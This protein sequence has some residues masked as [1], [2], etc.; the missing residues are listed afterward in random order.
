MNFYKEIVRRNA[1]MAKMG[2]FFLILAAVLGLYATVNATQVL[3]INSMIKPIKFALSTWIYAWSMAYLL[4][5]VEKQQKVRQYTYLAVATMLYENGV[6]TI[7]AFRGK[8]SHFNQS[9]IVGGI[10]YALMGIM[11]VWL[12]TATLVLTIR[13]IRQKTYIISDSFALSIQIGLVMFVIFSFFGGYMSGINSHNVGGEIGGEGLY[14][15]NWSTLFGDLRVAHFFG[16]HSLQLIPIFGYFI[17]QNTEN[18][19][20]E[21]QQ[22]WVF[23]ALYFLFVVFTMLQGLAGKPFIG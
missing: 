10:L 20:K 7:Q 19:S 5:Y 12:T 4:F 23:S 3:G 6:I 17:S 2:M 18:Q 16:V 15:L 13:F 14:L 8:L 21:K 1:L 9:E 11:I 22:V